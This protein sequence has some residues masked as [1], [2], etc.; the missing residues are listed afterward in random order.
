MNFSPLSNCKTYLIV[1]VFLN[2]SL[3]SF[4]Q[5]QDDT[6]SFWDNVNFG[7]SLGLSF[8][9]GFF[10]G[11]IAPM[12]IYEFTSDFSAGIG[13]NAT[14]NKQDDFF[15]STIFGASVIGLFNPIEELQLSAE[16]EQ[17]NVSRKF[18]NSVF[19]DDNYWYPALFMGIGYGNE[20]VTFGIRYDLLYSKEKSIYADAYV[21]FVR[22]FF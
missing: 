14:Y 6:S 5:N 15:K 19:K 12:G 4:S 17:L 9:D 7:G 16:F 13:L 11:T 10:S 21:P 22:V 20:N 1:F 3:A 8:G 2:C 18:D